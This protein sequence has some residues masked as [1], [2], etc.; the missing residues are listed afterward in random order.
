M[1]KKIYQEYKEETVDFLEQDP[2]KFVFDIEGFGFQTADHIARKNGLSLSHPNRIGAGCIYILEKSI[3][4]GHVYLPVEQCM[5]KVSQLLYQPDTMISSDDISSVIE[6]LNS[7][8][9]V[10]LQ[11]GRLYLPSLYYAEDGFAS[12]LNRILESPTDVD[13]PFAE[14]MK[15]I[16]DLVHT[17]YNV[18]CV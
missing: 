13:M 17:E 5:Q 4:Q 15:I 8:K 2:Y 1:S 16:A 11:E 18:D 3:Q 6:D 12:H 10:I 7:S 14:L 9:S